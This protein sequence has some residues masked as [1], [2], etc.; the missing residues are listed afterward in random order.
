M[1]HTLTLKID[2]SA[3]EER[4]FFELMST[5]S[6]PDIAPVLNSMLSKANNS[7]CVVLSDVSATYVNML[8][9][10]KCSRYILV[11]DVNNKALAPLKNKAIVRET[12]W[13]GFSIFIIDNK[14]AVVVSGNNGVVIEDSGSVAKLMAHFRKWFWNGA[15]F[16]LIDVVSGVDS[17]VFDAPLVESDGK[18]VTDCDE[19][20][21]VIT[22]RCDA[23]SFDGKYHQI[24]DDKVL[25]FSKIPEISI[26]KVHGKDSF[27]APDLWVSFCEVAGDKYVLN[28]N[29]ASYPTMPEK[30]SSK[31]IGIRV[32]S[33]EVGTIYKYRQKAAYSKLVGKSLKDSNGK[34]IMVLPSVTENVSVTM[35]L[36]DYL[37]FKDLE[38]KNPEMLE[39]RIRSKNPDLLV[40]NKRACGLEFQ[41]NVDIQ[42]HSQK[43]VKD[44]IY[45]VYDSMPGNLSR[46]K[47]ELVQQANNEKMDKLIAKVNK[48][49]IPDNITVIAEYNSLVTTLNELI[50]E[51]NSRGGEIDESLAEV[52]SS[53][54]AAK[55]K[56]I[57]KLKES[58]AKP[59]P[60]Y[61]ILYKN[62]G[63]YE[64]VL[65]DEKNLS[66]AEIEAE[67]RGW[68]TITYHLG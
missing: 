4:D 44:S 17:G 37:F 27:Y 51:F 63:T 41:I 52:S 30:G 39:D 65:T 25:Y 2:N 56:T 62:G 38:S 58:E 22:Q 26:L 23:S 19:S 24:L 20:I 18:V 6:V 11:S 49:Q 50:D 32:D 9:G 3:V 61:G 67:E 48:I 36:K 66:D 33:L 40:T 10:M 57:D 13:S 7:V 12:K 59:L 45:Q 28:Y 60:R 55:V 16:E 31:L 5:G 46:K 35:L 47:K 8:A 1:N 15:D 42:K 64:Y 54:K 14:S 68:K 34:D 43:A 29:P 53:K 21:S